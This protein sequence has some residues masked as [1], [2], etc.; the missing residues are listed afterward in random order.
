MKRKSIVAKMLALS[1]VFSGL[2]MTQL[3]AAELPVTEE[4]QESKAEEIPAGD[5]DVEHEAEPEENG[6]ATEQKESQDE[7]QVEDNKAQ[8]AP[9]ETDTDEKDEST[10]SATDE[11]D[12]NLFGE[13]EKLAGTE[14]DKQSDALEESQ[15]F[16]MSGNAKMAGSNGILYDDVVYLSA[17]NVMA[18]DEDMQDLYRD[19]CDEVSSSKE[20]GMTMEDVVFAVSENGDL[21]FSYYVPL[22]ALDDIKADL[23]SDVDEGKEVAEEDKK[24]GESVDDENGSREED[25]K[26]GENADDGKESIEEDKKDDE[27]SDDGKD[28]TEEDKKDDEGSDDGKGST[29]E[30]KK[31]DESSDDGKDSTEEDKKDDET[32]DDG[33]DTV[34]KED[35]ADSD[36][37]TE[38]EPEEDKEG[39]KEEELVIFEENMDELADP[40]EE[41][42]EIIEPVRIENTLDLGYGG[43]SYDELSRSGIN[44]NSVLPTEDYFV[45]QLS[46]SQKK[47]YNL[48]KDKLT[49]GSNKITFKESLSVSSSVGGDIAHAVSALMLAYPDKTDWVAKPGGF[50]G[51]VLYKLG[52]SVGD[53]TFTFDKSK[54]YSGSLDSKARTRVQTVGN[55]AIQYAAENYANAPVYGIVKYF[56][57]WVCENGYY[58]MLGTLPLTGRKGEDGTD[59]DREYLKS[60]GLNNTQINQVLNAYYKCHSAYG[61][62]LEGYGVCESYAK[63]M[64]RLLDAVGIPNFYVVGTAGT[65]DNVGGHAWNYVQMPNGQWYLL[66]STWNDT[67]ELTHTQ[68]T[69]E[70]LLVK[71]DGQHFASGCNYAGETPDFTFETLA[72][73]SYTQN[74]AAESVSLNKT[75]CNLIPKG[76]ETLTYTI[77]GKEDYGKVSGVWSSSNAKVAKV[78]QKGNVTAVAAGT[79]VITFSAAGMTAECTVNVDQ[80]KA[81]KVKNTGK[82]SENVSLGID[83][84]NKGSKDVV[85][86]VD[87]GN[88]PHDAAWMIQQSKA[89]QPKITY[90]KQNGVATAA[91]TVA[92][93]DITVKVQAE[94]D[95]S[96]NI[97]VKFGGKT[98]TIKVSAGK[99]ITKDMFDITWPAV[100]TG[101]EGSKTTAYTGKAV[102]PTIKKKSDPVYKPVTFKVSYV[103]N[104]D[105]GTAKALIQG[106]GKYGG[107]IELPF[108]ITPIDITSADF[109]KALK[110]KVYNGG[111]NPPA[112][113]VKLVKKTLKANKDY[114]ILYNGKTEAEVKAANGGVI[115]VGSYT[116]TIRGKGNYTGTVGTSQPY[117]ITQNTI[118]KVSVSGSSSVKF[119]GTKV[120]PYTIKIGKNVLPNTDYTI[121]WYSGQGNTMSSTLLKNPPTG[122]GKYTAIVRIK[123]DNLTTTPKK[124]EIVKK[125]T[126]K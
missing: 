86:T 81:V 23:L 58:E 104:K 22:I 84:A 92:G 110:S 123:G 79:A 45:T 14:Q 60:Q 10:V 73:A 40:E 96:V 105:A 63:T 83:G 49:K 18:M 39:L 36:Q 15:K 100:V 88:S 26:D 87:M 112:T 72:S 59:L 120:N 41:T 6:A 101:E 44:F 118:A 37:D 69:A 28:S 108:T 17:R 25:E 74:G 111:A 8:D 33:K 31:D 34:E 30:D 90:S 27:S 24:D 117:Q 11:T 94:K 68:S 103:N 75:E 82:T 20:G 106:T 57:Q 16:E 66:D 62:L 64:S 124:T 47:Y 97:P 46:A 116:I 50:S 21:Y 19:L 1:L 125:L 115:P 56:D 4:M 9:A 43:G 2:P 42:F 89:E 91:A 76:K 51:K 80:I 126:I 114:E 71:S 52:A 107:V 67:T 7:N 29:E 98:V 35:T 122:K 77:N 78:D 12:T 113:V 48:A 99:I 3:H 121:T 65:G 61:I 102:K 38:E 5:S 54:Y 70:Y 109:S 53:Y 119:T 13:S 85:L 55:E 93:N 32:S 95:G